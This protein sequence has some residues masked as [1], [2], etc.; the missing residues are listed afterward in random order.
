MDV[1]YAL[2]GLALGLTV[3]AVIVLIGVGIVSVAGMSFYPL[4]YNSYQTVYNQL[5]SNATNIQ[6]AVNTSFQNSITYV[7]QVSSYSVVAINTLRSLGSVLQIII[8]IGAFLL[9]LE[10]LMRLAMP[11]TADAPAGY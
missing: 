10:I 3:A 9:I 8:F 4:I 2:I 6:N 5:P 11:R 7:Q 1:A